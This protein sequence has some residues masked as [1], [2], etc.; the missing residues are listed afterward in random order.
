MKR[1]RKPQEK[2]QAKALFLKGNITKKEIAQRV[3]VQEKTI[4]NW[5]KEWDAKRSGLLVAVN[6]CFNRLNEKLADP[7]ADPN[8]IKILVETLGKLEKRLN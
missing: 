3:G 1:V 2:K 4:G 5:T 7:Q 8:E 6:N